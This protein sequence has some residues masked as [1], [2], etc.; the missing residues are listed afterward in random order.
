MGGGTVSTPKSVRYRQWSSRTNTILRKA[1]ALFSEVMAELD[2]E[3]EITDEVD[4]IIVAA[5]DA[6]SVLRRR[7]R[8]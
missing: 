6:L 8:D 1:E 2:I 7:A 4:N 5:T 3:D